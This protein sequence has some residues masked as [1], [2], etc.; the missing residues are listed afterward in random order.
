MSFGSQS[1]YFETY[2]K[3][4]NNRKN[5]NLNVTDH[6]FEYERICNSYYGLVKEGDSMRL[7]HDD[8]EFSL[9]DRAHKSSLNFSRHVARERDFY[10]KP[11]GIPD[12]PH[13]ER[14]NKDD[15]FDKSFKLSRNR[16]INILKFEKQIER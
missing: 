13:D 14:F 5:K 4:R 3:D 8:A 11:Y 9:K 2:L 16:A 7:I 12:G 1:I 15:N 6:A 10:P